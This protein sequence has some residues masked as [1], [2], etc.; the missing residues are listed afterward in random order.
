MTNQMRD[1]IEFC[2]HRVWGKERYVM[3]SRLAEVVEHR[4]D[5]WCQVDRYLYVDI[6]DAFDG[7]EIEEVIRLEFHRGRL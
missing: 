2:S 5:L 6:E 3:S 1:N 4:D 7:R